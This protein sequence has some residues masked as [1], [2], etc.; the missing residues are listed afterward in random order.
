MYCKPFIPKWS[1]SILQVHTSNYTSSVL[2]I[3]QSKCSTICSMTFNS[4]LLYHNPTVSMSP[5]GHCFVP[6]TIIVPICIAYIC[7]R[8]SCQRKQ[9]PLFEHG[10]FILWPIYINVCL[11]ADLKLRQAKQIRIMQSYDH[12]WHGRL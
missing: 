2:E 5:S 1:G 8:I 7:Q 6:L 3:F 12:E 9:N 11:V 10:M 4:E